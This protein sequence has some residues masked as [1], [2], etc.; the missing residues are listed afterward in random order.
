MQT[1]TVN[2]LVANVSAMLRRLIG[3]NIEVVLALNANAGFLRA[4][5][6]QLEQVLINLA[7]NAR[8]AMPDGGRLTIETERVAL[9]EGYASGHYE[10]QPGP[11]VM[12]AVSDTGTG[13]DEQTRQRIFE[14][15]F[16][17]KPEGKGTGLGLATVH[18]IVKQMNGSIFVYSEQGRGT[19]FKILFPTPA[20]PGAPVTPQHAAPHHPRPTETVLLVE[21]DDMVRK[22]AQRILEGAG[23]R[24]LLA[25]GPPQA[26]EAARGY[27]GTIHLLLSDVVMQNGYG[28]DLWVQLRAERDLP[29][30]FM[31]G[32]T[33]DSVTRQGILTGDFPFLSK[34]FTSGSLL[35]KVREVLD[36]RE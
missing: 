25:A 32:Y 1:V 23:Y 22:S 4:D 20:E 21:D 10:V 36:A 9:D 2:E 15:F 19:T 27:E 6:S 34:P 16:T 29:V 11:H 18:G 5:P 35:A 17:T 24:V 3:E 28:P 8:D 33:G 14:P 12:L 30:L 7:V 31:S 26:L 13:M